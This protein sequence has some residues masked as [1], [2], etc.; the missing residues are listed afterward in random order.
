MSQAPKKPFHFF[1]ELIFC[2]Y[3]LPT[4]VKDCPVGEPPSKLLGP[5]KLLGPLV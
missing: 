2:L 4:D 3:R 5:P 1:Q